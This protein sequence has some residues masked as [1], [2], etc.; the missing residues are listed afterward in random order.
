MDADRLGYLFDA[1][2]DRLY[3]LARRMTGDPEEA[4]DLLQDAFLRAAR[5]GRALPRTDEA[6]EAWL[7][8]TL[9][10]LC[11]DRARRL[12]VRAR[13]AREQRR[14]E[15]RGSA[16]E[17]RT[18]SRITVA[19]ALARLA[20]RRRAVIVLHEIDG[21][22]AAEIAR[23]LGV[24]RATVRW[25]LMMARRALKRLLLDERAPRRTEASGR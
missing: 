14:D 12:R 8:G 11:R 1:H 19:E 22:D 9:V 21:L 25:H 20:P 18:V 17:S 5:S 3:R 2:H 15:E 24:A 6:C 10:R 7:V 4:R 23:L 16:A 13:F